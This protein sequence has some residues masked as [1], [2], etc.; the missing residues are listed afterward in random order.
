M[1]TGYGP[2]VADGDQLLIAVPENKTVDFYK[3]L[4]GF[5]LT[6]TVECRGFTEDNVFTFSDTENQE[7]LSAIVA[8]FR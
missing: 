3:Y 1:E 5:G 7:R 8:K 4:R 2:V 6:F